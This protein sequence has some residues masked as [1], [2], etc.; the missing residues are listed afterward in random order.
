ML[1]RTLTMQLDLIKTS[2]YRLE[3]LMYGYNFE[4]CFGIELFDDCTSYESFKTKLKKTFPDSTPENVIA[5]E[6]DSLSFW[7]EINH[8]LNHRGD[9]SEGY[10]LDNNNQEQIESEQ[11][12]YTD[13]LATFVSDNAK[14]FAYPDEKGIPGYSVYWDYRFIIFGEKGSCL[15]IYGSASD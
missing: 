3:K 9:R 12:K 8:C 15:F 11:K 2:L 6:V 5:V 13:Y 1:I 14:I 10:W 4:V 7:E